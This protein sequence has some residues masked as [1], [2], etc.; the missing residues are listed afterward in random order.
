MW[1][2]VERDTGHTVAVKVRARFICALG[3]FRAVRSSEMECGCVYMRTAACQCWRHVQRSCRLQV[4]DLEGV[5]ARGE[6]HQLR[7][8]V[9][10]LWH[11]Q[12]PRVVPFYGFWWSLIQP[13][14]Q[15]CMV[16]V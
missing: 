6:L 13:N 14:P 3:A 16:R 1:R 9:E 5:V 11:C 7:R 8:E 12:H 15:F 10:M 4:I 2:A